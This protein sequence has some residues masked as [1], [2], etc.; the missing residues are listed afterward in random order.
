[1][2][3]EFPFSNYVSAGVFSVSVSLSSYSLDLLLALSVSDVSVGLLRDL[4]ISI[5]QLM[6]THIRGKS[7]GS[8]WHKGQDFSDLM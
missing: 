4:L 1:M 7:H 8:Y 3:A 6:N 5:Y 2:I